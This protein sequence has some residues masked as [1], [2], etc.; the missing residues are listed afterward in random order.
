MYVR[1]DRF[2]ATLVVDK[3]FSLGPRELELRKAADGSYELSPD[4]RTKLGLILAP[5]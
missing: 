4:D 5:H 3:T 2:G 1:S